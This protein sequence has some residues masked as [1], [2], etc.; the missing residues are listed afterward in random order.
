MRGWGFKAAFPAL[1]RKMVRDLTSNFNGRANE[2]LLRKAHKK[3]V[4]Q[5]VGRWRLNE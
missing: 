3:Y 5:F 1:G 4:R 2:T